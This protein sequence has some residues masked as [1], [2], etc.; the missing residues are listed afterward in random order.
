[1]RL[2]SRYL[3]SINI[4]TDK[5]ADAENKFR[6]YRDFLIEQNKLFNLTAI[7][8]PQEIVTKHF[9]DSLAA[10]PYVNG[11]VADI[12]TGAGFPGMVLAIVMQQNEFALID[13]LNK[14]VNFLN[15][16]RDK[17]GLTNAHAIHSRAEYLPKTQT[18]DTIVSRAVSRLNTLCEYCLPFVKNGGTFIS[19]KSDDCEEVINEAKTAI[20]ILGGKIEDVK[21]VN[22]FGT[23][24]VRKLVLIKKIKETPQKYPRSQNKPKKQPL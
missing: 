22:V 6:V 19:Y 7:T 4:P 2:I 17:L 12:G 21:Q 24:I 18:Y 11:K 23:D 15:E 16:L 14:R 1:M 13:S 8:D 3:Q 9:I 5:A 20:K 10:L